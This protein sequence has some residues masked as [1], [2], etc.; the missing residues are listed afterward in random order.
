MRG[1]DR[2]EHLRLFL[3]NNVDFNIPSWTLKWS[4]FHTFPPYTVLTFVVL[5]TY[6]LLKQR[7]RYQLFL[8]NFN[9]SITD[10]RTLNE[11]HVT[12]NNELHV[13]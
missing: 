2:D 5:Y 8:F 6:N 4:T 10:H 12:N 11:L 13:L 7:F 9:L 3:S 1:Y